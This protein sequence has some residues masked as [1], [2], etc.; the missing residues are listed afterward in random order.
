MGAPYMDYLIADRIV[1]PPTE[2]A[3]YSETVVYL[4]DC[5]QPNDSTRFV[6]DQ[7]LTRA[8][9][10]LPERGFVFCSFNNSFKITPNVFNLW[11][12]ILH[13]V[14]S[15]VLWLL[16]DNAPATNNLRR[17]A[18]ARGISANRLVFAKRLPL[19]DHL[20]RHKL[21]DLFL[22]TLPYNAHTTAS[23]ALWTGLPVLTQI[24]TTFAGRVAASLLTALGLPELIVATEADYKRLAVA[25]G[26][27]LGWLGATKAKL[28]NNRA[29]SPLFNSEIITRHLEAAYKA[30][31]DAQSIAAP[32]LKKSS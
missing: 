25:F 21:A 10:G 13:E 9:C 5:Y 2:K 23:D 28:A 30:M 8:E 18:A 14:E 12:E 32:T 31:N 1:I 17:E 16:E 15:S 20:A 6:A 4:P 26:N 24:G 19:A 27:N 22:D 3:N 11:M 29:I 7:T